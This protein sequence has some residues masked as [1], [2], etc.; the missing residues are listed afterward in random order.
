MECICIDCP[1]KCYEYYNNYV[2]DKAYYEWS[3][4]LDK[5]KDFEKRGNKIDD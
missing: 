4:K 1:D 2:S 5:C 3:I